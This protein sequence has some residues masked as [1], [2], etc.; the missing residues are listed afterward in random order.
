MPRFCIF[1]ESTTPSSRTDTV[2]AT[3]GLPMFREMSSTKSSRNK[4]RRKST[5]GTFELMKQ[6]LIRYSFYAATICL[7]GTLAVSSALAAK[8]Q[9]F[10][11]IVGDAVC[12]AKHTMD[13]DDI[14]CLRT[15]I[16]RGSKYDLVVGE[17]VYVLSFKDQSIAENLDKLASQQAKAQVK[18]A[19][20]GE[21]IDVESVGAAR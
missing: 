8:P 18:G 5:G 17:K 11:G 4:Q 3:S 13:G 21:S 19:A 6:G 14:S 7:A 1:W 20:N 12:G 9:T 16:Q 15:C 2:V 10:V